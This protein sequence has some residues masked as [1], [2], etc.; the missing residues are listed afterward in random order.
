MKASS[1]QSQLLPPKVP[2][3]LMEP[4]VATIATVENLDSNY[5]ANAGLGVAPTQGLAPWLNAHGQASGNSQSSGPRRS[6]CRRGYIREPDVL[7]SRLWVWQSP[8]IPTNA[9]DEELKSLKAALSEVHGSEAAAEERARI[10]MK[11]S[12]DWTHWSNK[13]TSELKQICS[14]LVV[15]QGGA[16]RNVTSLVRQKLKDARKQGQLPS[17]QQLAL[18]LQHARASASAARLVRDTNTKILLRMALAQQLTCTSREDLHGGAVSPTCRK[19][20]IELSDARYESETLRHEIHAANSTCRSLQVALDTALREKEDLRQDQ[21]DVQ[22]ELWELIKGQVQF[23]REKEAALH[24]YAEAQRQNTELREEL[25]AAQN[26]SNLKGT[27]W[28]E[29]DTNLARER[30]RSASGSSMAS[31]SAR[32]RLTR[33]SDLLGLPH[34]PDNSGASSP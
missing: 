19:V 29:F 8:E 33:L 28:V 12:D 2:R 13:L 20:F 31:S 32:P 6:S 5:E 9:T 10:A 3:D 22:K 25:A 24:S 30:H 27:T 17:M 7:G 18:D 23:R 1:P 4:A 26:S 15:M 34:S 14:Q 16:P 11:E 21:Q